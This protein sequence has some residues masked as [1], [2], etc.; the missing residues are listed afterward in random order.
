MTINSAIY[1]NYLDEALTAFVFI[2]LLGYIFW[3]SFKTDSNGPTVF[4]VVGCIF[5][6]ALHPRKFLFD[7]AQTGPIAC[8]PLIA[9]NHAFISDPQILQKL[10]QSKGFQIIDRPPMQLRPPGKNFYVELNGHAWTT[11][12]KY[13]MKALHSGLVTQICGHFLG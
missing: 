9:S 6:F 11:R 8:V 1:L 5:E 10:Y 7:I 4:P 2:V 3:K 12:R 13:T